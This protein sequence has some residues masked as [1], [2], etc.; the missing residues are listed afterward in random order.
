MPRIAV[1][2]GSGV[3]SL[4][5]IENPEKKKINTRFGESPEI[6]IGEVGGKEVAFMPRHGEGHSEPPHKINFRANLWSLKKLEVERV[7]ATT[8]VGSLN[9][10]FEPGEFVL[11]DQ[12]L[13]FTKSRSSTFYDGDDDAVVHVDMTEPY[14][15]E[16][17]NVLFEMGE[18]LD[19]EVHRE[20]TYVCTEGPRFETAAEIRIFREL[21][22]DVVGMT[23]VPESVLARELEM[24]YSTVSIVTNLA[25][26]ISEEKLTHKEVKEIME[27]N[28]R[29]VKE[30]V[31]SSIPNIPG[32]R[33]CSCKNALKGAKVET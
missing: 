27:E 31:F 32:E 9:S 20:G 28:I 26:G 7:I 17:R 10:D 8:A 5:F 3:Y 1:I 33:S 22:A 15:P 29:N 30:L 12:F 6:I 25:A 18:N 2:G 4:D 16:L 13:D 23:N 24:C 19:I 11:L 14:C 21:G